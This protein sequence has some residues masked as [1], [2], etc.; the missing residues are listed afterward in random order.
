M[1]KIMNIGQAMKR[2][3]LKNTNGGG[4]FP[5]QGTFCR[6]VCQRLNGNT[7]EIGIAGGCTVADSACRAQAPNSR[8]I[9]CGN[10][11]TV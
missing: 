4:P 10:C 9:S 6:V 3:E 8:A 7:F 1:K 5:V 2:N 11:V